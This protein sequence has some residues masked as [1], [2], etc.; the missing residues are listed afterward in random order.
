MA[1]ILPLAVKLKKGCLF[2]DVFKALYLSGDRLLID[3]TVFCKM[4][5][6]SEPLLGREWLSLREYYLAK[7]I[8]NNC[9]R[10][11]VSQCDNIHT[12]VPLTLVT[13]FSLTL[14]TSFFIVEFVCPLCVSL[15]CGSNTIA[16]QVLQKK[17]HTVRFLD[18]SIQLA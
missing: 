17:A 5:V 7:M 9:E 10:Y 4:E 6:E 2:S 15:C 14:S 8:V 1:D 13:L 12:Y 18:I 11:Q 16:I 3:L